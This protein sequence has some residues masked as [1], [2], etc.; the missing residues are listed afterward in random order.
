[1][2]STGTWKGT[3]KS[4]FHSASGLG[5]TVKNTELLFGVIQVLALM[6]QDILD[7]FKKVAASLPKYKLEIRYR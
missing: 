3:E 1:M 5:K 6:I 4:C 7:A 2:M